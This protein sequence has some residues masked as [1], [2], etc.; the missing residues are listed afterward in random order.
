MGE[1]CNRSADMNV[2]P[3]TH[4]RFYDGYQY[5]SLGLSRNHKLV[6]ISV[7]RDAD[8][9]R[10]SRF[11]DTHK[12]NPVI[13][14]L[15]FSGHDMTRSEDLVREKNKNNKCEYRQMFPHN[16]STGRASFDKSRASNFRYVE[17]SFPQHGYTL[18]S[19]LY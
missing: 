16:C 1:T 11:N 14:V 9:I 13:A 5:T 15:K 8:A 17:R 4:T 10:P 2:I 12:L 3:H 6:K 7:P 19:T 18:L